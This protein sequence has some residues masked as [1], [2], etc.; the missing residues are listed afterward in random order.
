MAELIRR[1][2][3]RDPAARPEILR[4]RWIVTNGLGGFA[5]GTLH[6]ILGSRYHGLLVAALGAPLGRMMMLN[7]LVERV[8][9]GGGPQ[10]IIG[11]GDRTIP[12]ANRWKGCGI[13]TGTRLAV[14]RYGSTAPIE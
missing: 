1:L 14:W 12:T 3:L 6:G 8:H 10:R 11:G 2:S 4:R 13:P 7:H 9:F 5:S